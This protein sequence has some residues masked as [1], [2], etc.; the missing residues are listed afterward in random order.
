M[1]AGAIVVHHTVTSHHAI[2]MGATVELCLGVFT[3]VGAALVATALSLVA[4]GRRRSHWTL[5]ATVALRV[6]AAPIARSRDGPSLACVLCVSR[7]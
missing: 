4:I 2:G 5:P 1:L 3:A 7:R 6:S